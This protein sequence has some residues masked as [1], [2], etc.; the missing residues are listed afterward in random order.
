MENVFK[1]IYQGWNEFARGF[2][3]I[4][5][6]VILSLVYILLLGPIWLLVRLFKKDLLASKTLKA[7]S[8]WIEREGK[9][10]SWK[11]FTGNFEKVLIKK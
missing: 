4:Q 5:N 2:A 9:N 8:F 7:N 1:H 6:M 11:D 3:S 10:P